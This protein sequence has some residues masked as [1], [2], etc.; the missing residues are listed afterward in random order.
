[1]NWLC[2]P[3]GI[4][5]L[6]VTGWCMCA[7]AHILLLTSLTAHH[8]IC[9]AGRSVY[10]HLPLTSLAGGW[11]RCLLDDSKL[12]PCVISV[13]ALYAKWLVYM[14]IV[15]YSTDFMCAH[16][17]IWLLCTVYLATCW[18]MDNRPI[19]ATLL[20]AHCQL[21]AYHCA[22]CSNFDYSTSNRTWLPAE[23]KHITRQRKRN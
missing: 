8:L 3:E 16:S 15:L 19:Y 1:M 14:H 22:W 11:F 6:W 13:Y 4:T 23:L 20:K 9:A 17:V 7:N 5:D 12:W 18:F 10:W 2:E 21:I